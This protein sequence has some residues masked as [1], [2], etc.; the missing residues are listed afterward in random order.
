MRTSI[1]YLEP[2]VWYLN[3]L[4][5]NKSSFVSMFLS[6]RLQFKRLLVYYF[7]GKLK[8]LKQNKIDF[9]C[10][11]FKPLKRKEI[12]QALSSLLF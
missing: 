6:C 8:Q 2:L 7:L 9:F 5:L 1:G 4:S 12:N 11:L 10:Y 3:W